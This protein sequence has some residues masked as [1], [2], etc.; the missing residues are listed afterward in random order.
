[1]SKFMT[2]NTISNMKELLFNQLNEI[3][4]IENEMIKLKN[5]KHSL[6]PK[7]V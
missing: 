6:T 7:F 2:K 3:L 1:M 5:Y 4:R